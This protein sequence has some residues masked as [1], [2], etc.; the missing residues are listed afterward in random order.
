MQG[1]KTS[2]TFSWRAEQLDRAHDFC[3]G[4]AHFDIY[5]V[6]TDYRDPYDDVY[7]VFVICD[8]ATYTWLSC[9]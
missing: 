7:L 4:R 8:D 1:A 6:L 3:R 9:L 5:F 2:H